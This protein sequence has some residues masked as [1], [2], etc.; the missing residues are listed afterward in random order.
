MTSKNPFEV[1]LDVMKLARDMLE[2]DFEARQQKYLDKL[3]VLKADQPS[4]NFAFSFIENNA[5]TAYTSS[6]I[7]DKANELYTFVNSSRVK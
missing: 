3:E 7:L 1:R 4:P 2:K 6:D 5:P